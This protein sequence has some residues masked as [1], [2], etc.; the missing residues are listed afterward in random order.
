M[1]GNLSVWVFE[2]YNYAVHN[3][4]GTELHCAPS[5]CVVHHRLALCI[6][7]VLCT[8][9]HRGDPFTRGRHYGGAQS[10]PLGP[11]VCQ[12]NTLLMHL[13]VINSVTKFIW[14]KSKIMRRLKNIAF[15]EFILL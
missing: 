5:T 1:F 2:T 12:S 10:S 8:M 13:S 3:F 6:F 15:G 4:N 14:V 9:L 7:F 11:S